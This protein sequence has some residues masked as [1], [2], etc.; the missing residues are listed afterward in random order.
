MSLSWRSSVFT[1]FKCVI[2]WLDIISMTIDFLNCRMRCLFI[3][4]TIVQL[5]CG[6]K[7]P[8]LRWST[9]ISLIQYRALGISRL[10]KIKRAN[11]FLFKTLCFSDSKRGPSPALFPLQPFF[12]LIL[13]IC[14]NSL[15]T[16]CARINIRILISLCNAKRKNLVYFL[17]WFKNLTKKALATKYITEQSISKFCT[18]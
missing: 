3:S 13:V 14:F 6:K 17:I 7:V 15:N 1:Y 16:F 8:N 2:S 12:R 11:P 4:S 9:N 5:T 18:R 10:L